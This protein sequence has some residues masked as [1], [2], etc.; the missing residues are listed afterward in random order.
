LP[1]RI[2]DIYER[3]FPSDREAAYEL[4]L[5]ANT[6]WIEG[7]KTNFPSEK[8]FRPWVCLD[9]RHVDKPRRYNMAP[10]TS[11]CKRLWPCSIFTPAGVIPGLNN[12]GLILL[13][14][15]ESFDEDIFGKPAEHL[16]DWP[17]EIKEEIKQKFS[18]W[19]HYREGVK[20]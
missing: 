14:Y 15:R 13:Y 4:K 11:D 1:G 2:D 9:N 6:W 7:N 16:G 18:T 5:L 3:I 19:R 12:E 8:P 20:I 10:R 17:E